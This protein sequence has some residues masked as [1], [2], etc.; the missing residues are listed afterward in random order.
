MIISTGFEHLTHYTVEFI[1][2]PPPV[3]SQCYDPAEEQ[4]FGPILRFVRRVYTV[5]AV[6]NIIDSNNCN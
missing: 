4:T 5:D 1:A 2:S 3:P 6:K